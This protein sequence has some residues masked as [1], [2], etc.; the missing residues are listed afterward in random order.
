M[1]YSSFHLPEVQNSVDKLQM[2]DWMTVTVKSVQ[3]ADNFI[4]LA[5]EHRLAKVT[6]NI[7]GYNNQYGNTVPAVSTP[8]FYI[9]DTECDEAVT[10]NRNIVEGYM[11]SDLSGNGK[12]SFTAVLS[13]GK[14]SADA[15]F[16]SIVVGSQTLAI[17][18]AAYLTTEGLQAGSAYT[19]SLTVGKDAASISG[20]SV[21]EWGTGWNEEGTATTEIN[22]KEG[23]PLTVDMISESINN[24]KLVVKGNPSS[25]DLTILGNYI[26]DHPEDI[27]TLD[28]ENCNIT[29]IPEY[30][31]YSVIGSTVVVD[32]ELTTLVL[33]KGTITIGNYAFYSTQITS[34]TLP[35]TVTTIGDGAFR[36]GNFTELT[37]PA[38]VNKIG[39]YA[40]QYNNSL[41]TVYFKS[42]TP[43]NTIGTV[44]FKSNAT[45]YAPAGSKDAYLQKLN[46]NRYKIEEYEP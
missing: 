3:T 15:T 27:N 36:Y 44:A 5:F 11:V 16:F 41:L 6:V 24:G 33:P 26:I 45:I 30:F 39:N 21:T 25:D 18:P 42:S 46:S 13:A 28:M 38:S 1:S 9:A 8:K 40:F 22:L 31:I 4:S 37:I 29:E 23:E 17:Q 43:L 10:S 32:S 12:H 34:I 14:Y 19:L 35:E 20:I 7:S 2:A